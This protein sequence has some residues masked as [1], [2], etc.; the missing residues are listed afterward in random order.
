MTTVFQKDPVE[1]LSLLLYV[2]K[3]SGA[4]GNPDEVSRGF[5]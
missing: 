1:G 3:F 2:W 4:A 5:P